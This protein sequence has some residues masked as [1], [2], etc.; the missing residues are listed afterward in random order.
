MNINL[1]DIENRILGSEDEFKNITVIEKVFKKDTTKCDNLSAPEIGRL[2][3]H[4]DKEGEKYQKSFFI[5]VPYNDPRYEELKNLDKY[6]K[7]IYVYTTLFPQYKC[8]LPHGLPHPKFY[9][10]DGKDV[11]ILEDLSFSAYKREENS[12]LSLT[13]FSVTLR[14]LAKFHALSV[15]VQ[16]TQPY[17]L[18]ELKTLKVAPHFDLFSNPERKSS[19]KKLFRKVVDQTDATFAV[20]HLEVL[21]YFENYLPKI[22]ENI[23]KFYNKLHVLNH[24]NMCTKNVWFAYDDLGEV[25]DVKFTNF[26]YCQWDAPI[27]DIMLLTISSLPFEIFE[28]T[29]DT[30][31][32]IYTSTFNAT[33]EKLK[34]DQRL[35]VDEL[36]GFIDSNY[37]YFLY[38]LIGIAPSCEEASEAGS[39]KFSP[40]EYLN[41]ESYDKLS[42]LWMSYIIE[43]GRQ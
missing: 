3:I 37:E 28:Q 30:L 22:P 18:N 41:A 9:G 27:I 14:K 24:G 2:T 36:R 6:S 4:Y 32:K 8:L 40:K 31:L 5:Q 7:E 16:G 34:C 19:M 10:T 13:Q 20:K 35:S 43:K 1:V 11:L 39:N 15:K 12:L 29:F 33:L 38:F 23:Q 17:I 42:K 25:V 21:L 26:Q